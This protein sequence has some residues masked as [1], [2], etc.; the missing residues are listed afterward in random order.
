MVEMIALTT[1]MRGQSFVKTL[2]AM[3]LNTHAIME[4]VFL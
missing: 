2:R 4:N 1:A 3:P